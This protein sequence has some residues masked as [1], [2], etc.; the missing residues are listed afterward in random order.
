[1]PLVPPPKGTLADHGVAEDDVF[2][3]AVDEPEEWSDDALEKD[4]RKEQDERYSAI[5]DREKAVQDRMKAKNPKKEREADEKIGKADM[6]YDEAVR[7]QE[8]LEQ[9]QKWREKEREDRERALAKLPPPRP[10]GGG[11]GQVIGPEEVYWRTRDRAFKMPSA[12]IVEEMQYI[13][14]RGIDNPW[15]KARWDALS[16]EMQER[17]GTKERDQR[18]K[19]RRDGRDLFPWW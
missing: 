15:A 10:P 2:D 1:M 14:A 7:R 19:D 17:V 12:Y 13:N 3:K 18:Y 6:R 16:A 4:W 9:A 11:G 8:R 5:E